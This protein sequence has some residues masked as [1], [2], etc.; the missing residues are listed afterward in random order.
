MACIT[1]EQLWQSMIE[2]SDKACRNCKHANYA[3]R[4]DQLCKISHL[5]DWEGCNGIDNQRWEW[6]GT[7]K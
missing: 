3:V 6:N 4:A 2:P 5:P 1:K 7:T